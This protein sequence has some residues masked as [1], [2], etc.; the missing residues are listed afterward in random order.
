MGTAK[1]PKRAD[2][3]QALTANRLNDGLVVFFTKG[4]HWS[5]RIN[6][7][8]LLAVEA[9]QAV[10]DS[11]GE[12]AVS[13]NH[14]VAPYLIDVE[15]GGGDINPTR[16]RERIRAFGPTVNTVPAPRA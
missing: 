14:V 9:S 15:T 3:V 8:A 5:R 13:T 11:A 4:G 2:G 10:L 16:F 6:D 1:Q 12:Y 7:A